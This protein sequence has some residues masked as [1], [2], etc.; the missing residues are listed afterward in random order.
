[1]IL[2]NPATPDRIDDALLVL[3]GGGGGAC[4]CQYWRMSATEYRRATVEERAAR[5]RA[6]AREPA[7]PGLVAYLDGEPAAWCGLGP[8]ASFERLTRSRT[9]PPIDDLPVWSIVCFAVRVG[10]RRRG[11]AHALLAGAV[12]YARTQG[13]PALEA[14]PVDVGEGRIHQTAAYVGTVSLFEQAGFRRLAETGARSARLPRWTV[15]LDLSR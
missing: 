11:L 9:I 14:Y 1:M 3:S 12:D 10:F 6:Q 4:C 7:A 2:V 15:R 8:R 13:A 5:L